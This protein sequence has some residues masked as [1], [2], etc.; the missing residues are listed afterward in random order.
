MKPSPAAPV[1]D[2]RGQLPDELGEL[3]AIVQGPI[4][5]DVILIHHGLELL[6]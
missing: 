1:R 3:L 5:V 2:I 4:Q 6:L